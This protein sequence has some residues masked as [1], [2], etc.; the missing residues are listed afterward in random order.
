[1]RHMLEQN[2]GKS[3]QHGP[4]INESDYQYSKRFRLGKKKKPKKK[5]VNFAMKKKKKPVKSL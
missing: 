2:S 4:N 1:M 3:R 5:T